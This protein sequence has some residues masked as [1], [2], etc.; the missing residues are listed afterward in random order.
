MSTKNILAK[1]I[2]YL[3]N[4]RGFEERTIKQHQRICRL[5]FI[6]MSENI[7]QSV[8]NANP[9]D[10]LEY[11]ELQQQSGRVN[12]TSLSGEI[13]VIRTF[14]TWLFDT[15]KVHFNPAASIPELICEPP[16]E[17]EYLTIEECFRLLDTF[18]TSRFQ[19]LR[20]YTM[21][22]LLWSTGIRNSELCGLN[23]RDID[24][25][26]GTLLVRKGKGGKQRLLFLND[27]IRKDMIE[28]RKKAIGDEY[29]PVFYALSKNQFSVQ[30][31][32]RI[33]QNTVVGL[34]RKYADEAE[35]PKRVHPMALRHTFATHMYQAGVCMRDIK[36][37]LGHDDETE[38]TIY[39]HVN[40]DTVKRFLKQHIG[41]S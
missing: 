2:E 8:L 10:I 18:D 28:F 11:I 31:H 32:A 24:F 35:L 14:Y 41:N 16:A 29:S 22:A 4:I 17:K 25:D 7:E 1:Y 9:L 33:N 19:G 27:R 23:W 20:N 34:I 3:K 21:T 26:E 13:C 38:T 5:W 30:K 40:V 39:V 36:E 37:M 12:N 15:G 6:F